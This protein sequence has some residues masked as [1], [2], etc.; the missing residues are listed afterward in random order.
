[1]PRRRYWIF[2]AAILAA[3]LASTLAFPFLGRL[4]IESDAIEPSDAILVLAGDFFGPRVLK[5]AELGAQ[6]LAPVVLIS[7]TG[8]GSG[9]ESDQAIGFLTGRGYPRSL[10]RGLEHQ[11]KSTV[12]EAIALAPQLHRLG[13]RKATLVTRASHSRRA[14]LVFRLFCPGIRFRSVPAEEMEFHPVN[15]WKD[16]LSQQRVKEEWKKILGTVLWE[17]PLF[18]AGRL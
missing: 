16:P 18:L 17:Y 7:G 15:W 11:S 10:F 5:G 14:T 13:V 3:C 8:Y 9:G 1:M 4:L 12:E 6:G 2:L